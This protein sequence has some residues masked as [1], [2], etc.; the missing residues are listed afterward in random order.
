VRIWN[1]IGALPAGRE[2]VVASIGNYDGVHL[3]HQEILR[4]VVADARRRRVDALLVTF[5]PHPVAVLAPERSPRLLQTRRQK[6][7]SLERTGLTDLLILDFD[8][9]LAALDGEAFF[10]R[11]LLERVR[12]AAIH[13]G[14]SF[15]FGRGRTGDVELLR[16][17][18]ERHGF[19]VHGVPTFRIGG[20][21]VSSS[22]IRAALDAGEVERARRMLSRPYAVA[23]EV[24]PGDG[25]GR[26]LQCPTANLDLE[27]SL[28]PRAGVYVTESVVLAS[29]IPSVTNV[30]T[31]PTFGGQRLTVETHLLGFDE[32]LYHERLEL[33]FLA[34]LRDERR[35]P[36]ASALADQIAR[37]RA[38]AEAFFQNRPLG[39][40]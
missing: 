33:H 3:G 14:E 29:R 31:R 19:E 15:R 12:F 27:N 34:R 13:V 38:A 28:V 9:V 30:G 39:A 17:I 8:S 20:E 26:G 37:D 23:G 5:D 10:E 40:P 22:A 36:D 24:V 18:G 4:R 35:F 32:N 6:I 25:R 16:R 21:P 1:G 11:V 2:P 7:D